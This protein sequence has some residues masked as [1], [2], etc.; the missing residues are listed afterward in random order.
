M[1]PILLPFSFGEEPIYVG[2]S[3]Q[4]TC[5]VTD[6]DLPL[7]IT[8]S[9]NGTED[10]SFFGVMTGKA[11]RRAK[12]LIIESVAPKHQGYYTCSVRNPARTV[13]YT[14]NLKIHG[15]YLTPRV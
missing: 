14:A 15:R 5:F 4:L 10:L 6:G 8:W 12:L 11:G 9:F 13:S 1:S 2:Q 3:A 7:E